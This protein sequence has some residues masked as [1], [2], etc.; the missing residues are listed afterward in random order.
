[1]VAWALLWDGLPPR[2]K[3]D[4]PPAAKDDKVQCLS[5]FAAT[6][7][8]INQHLTPFAA[9][10]RHHQPTFVILRG[11]LHHQQPTLVVLRGN[12]CHQQQSLSSFAQRRI[13]FFRP[14]ILREYKGQILPGCVLLLDQSDLLRSKTVLEILLP[15]DRIV[16]VGE[17]A[18]SRRVDRSCTAR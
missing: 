7:V 18:R 11:N 1:M 2:R 9:T 17:T 8:T 3:A 10:P 16:D 13:C 4:P 12:P 15:G 5:S 14:V 6:L